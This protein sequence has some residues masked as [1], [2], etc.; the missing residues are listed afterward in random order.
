MK[1]QQPNLKTNF[2]LSIYPRILYPFIMLLVELMRDDL[3]QVIALK[4]LW[5]MDL[6]YKNQVPETRGEGKL[7]CS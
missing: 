7:Y 3:L 6:N 1:Y 4:K 5:I 2:N